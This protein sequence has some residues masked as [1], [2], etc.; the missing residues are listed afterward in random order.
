MK[1][2]ALDKNDRERLMNKLIKS[3][4]QEVKNTPNEDPENL[5][6]KACLDAMPMLYEFML[7]HI[8]YSDGDTD[9]ES[10]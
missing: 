2:Q 3:V 7:K 10:D 9:I 6:S 8:D 4:K 5:L 1:F